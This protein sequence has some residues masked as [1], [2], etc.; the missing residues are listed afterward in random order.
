MPAGQGAPPQIKPESLDDYL[1][2][3]SKAVFQSGISWRVVDAKWPGIKE[4]FNDFQVGAIAAMGDEQIDALADDARLIRNRRKIAA[5]VHNARW[6]IE[7]ED[8]YDGFVNYLRSFDDFYALIADMRK[9]FKFMGNMG[10]YYWMWVVGE[11][12]PPHDEFSARTARHAAS[13]A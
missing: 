1:E 4:A 2:V 7:L 9:Q 11:K 13:P 6:M 8:E 3:Q 5:I 10:V 12:V